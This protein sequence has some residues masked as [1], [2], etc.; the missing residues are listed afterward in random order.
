MLHFRQFSRI[1]QSRIVKYLA[2]VAMTFLLIGNLSLAPAIAQSTPAKA[3][4]VLDGQRLFQVAES[5]QFSAQERANL[6]NLRLQEAIRS[7]EPIDVRTEERNQQPTLLLNNRY[8]LTIT[9]RDI[10]PGLTPAEQAA[11]WERELQQA[12]QQARVER[13]GPYVQQM[14]LVSVLLIILA[15]VIHRLLGWIERRCERFLAQWL[16]P[17]TEEESIPSPVKLLLNLLLSLMRAGLWIVTTLYITNL[18]PVTRQWSYQISSL[19]LSSL[20]SPILTL[21]RNAYSLTDLL[22]LVGLLFG[23]VIFASAVTN[24]LR[25]RVLQLAGISRSGQEAITILTK[26]SLISIGV[27]VLLQ[28]WGLDISSLTILA[29]A[30]GVGIGFGFQDIAKNFG[31][32]LVLMFERPIKVGDF[33]EINQFVGTIERIGA[34]ST[35]IRTL[36]RISIIV[37]N[38]RF[39]EAEVINWSHGNPISR[40]HLPVG[41]AFG[42]DPHVVQASLLEAAHRQT[43]VLQTPPPQVLFKG[44]GDSALNFE[45]LVWTAQPAQQFV[46]KSDLYYQIY[47][48]LTA[49]GIE[50]PFPQRDVNLRSGAIGLAPHLEQALIRLAEAT[51]NGQ[52]SDNL[53]ES[54]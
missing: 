16:P 50:I 23:L 42:C 32:G 35:E 48:V 47:D 10:A 28:I 44:F 15:A 13:T 40:L 41:V 38:S 43:H 52:T 54:S 14:A 33:V 2:L 11:L 24:L 31:S 1:A 49:Q 8:L 17:E 53:P 25:L 7:S 27:L 4:I 36:D 18:F 26:Y 30:L 45:L 34:R 39:L 22:I 5:G 12:I 37:P 20:T 9:K 19:L 3:A 46:L 21:G 29:S 6:V 51:P